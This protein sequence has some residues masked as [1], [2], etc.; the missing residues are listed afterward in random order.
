MTILFL[1][2]TIA[3]AVSRITVLGVPLGTLGV[4]SVALAF[5]YF[6]FTV[7]SAVTDF[8]LLLFLYSIG[9]L[10]G[11][12]FFRTVKRHGKRLAA[13]TL[14]SVGSSA[15]IVVFS[16]AYF[17][18]GWEKTIGLLCGVLSSTPALASAIDLFSQTGGGK[19]LLLG[20]SL[21]YPISLVA[22][23][24][25]VQIIPKVFS[26]D[27]LGEEAELKSAGE[28][29]NKLTKRQ[30]VV[31]N[32]N[33]EGV[34]ISEVPLLRD[35]K[36]NL[37]RVLHKGQEV[38]ASPSVVLHVGD[39]VTA[40]AT[41]EAHKSLRIIFGEE[42]SVPSPESSDL[43]S[44][45]V[46][47]TADEYAWKSLR[48]L[49]IRDRFGITVTRVRRQGIEFL[50]KGDFE[51]E[52]G[53]HLVLL[54]E[55]RA[56]DEFIATIGA[57]ASRVD[58]TNMLPFVS[59]LL[60]GAIIGNMEIPIPGPSP[61]IF[62][63]G[64]A[65][66]AFLVSLLVGHFGRIGPYRVYVPRAARNILRELGLLLFLVG[67]GVVAGANIGGVFSPEGAL[68]V[69]VSV[70]AVFGSLILTAIVAHRILKM[71][72]LE[73]AGSL[74]GVMNSSAA[75]PK[76]GQEVIDHAAVIYASTYPLALILKLVTVQVL[77]YL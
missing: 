33:L 62:R 27:Y 18:F 54:G 57:N 11:P 63:L 4:L 41:E 39:I 51:V 35:E 26:F 21:S 74:C 34:R 37:S 65:G 45:E 76:R 9:L 38:A 5:G 71:S 8:G 61:M 68:M 24:L 25:S 30:F 31:T 52:I 47:V 20:Y 50:P 22:L 3:A 64:P 14:A 29:R 42:T 44:S 59:G 43:T 58:E 2:L 73:T 48:D 10:V 1:I 36:G 15:A 23:I 55:K 60:L 77:G 70:I 56:V 72:G 66:G 75:L 53:D 13:V 49:Q 12:R 17:G 67:A 40:V 7:P 46:V 19:D 69:G 28:K 16:A 6:G 32:P